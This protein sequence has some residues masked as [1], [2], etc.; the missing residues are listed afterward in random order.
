MQRNNRDYIL[1]RDM[2][3]NTPKVPFKK[4]F[5]I[6]SGRTQDA[7]KSM[8]ENLKRIGQ[9][10]VFTLDK[11]D[12]ILLFCPIAS[13]VGTDISEA[14]ENVPDDKQVIMVVMHH[15]FNPEHIVADSRRL[16]T[17]TNV[18]LVVDTLFYDGRFLD[19]NRN[20]IALHEIRTLLGVPALP[21]PVGGNSSLPFKKFFV[22][23]SGRTQDAHK[24]MVENLKRIDQVEVPTLE[25]S[26]YILLFCPIASREGMD[27]SEALENVPD[28][29]Q[30]IMVVMHHTFNPEHIVAD[31]RRLVTNTNVCLVVDTLF[32]DGHFLG[33]CNRNEIA[34]HEIRTLLGVPA[35]PSPVGGNSSLP[36]KKFF[37]IVSGRTQDAHKSMVENLKRI[38]QVEVSTLDKS[39]YILLFCP[40]ASREGMDVSE[41]LE[42]VPDDKQVIMV[43]MHH[44]FNPEQ[45]VA[46][47]RR[48]VTNPNVCLVVDTLFYDG[49][50][51]GNC[52]RNEIALYEMKTLLGVPALLSRFGGNSSL[53]FKKFF[54]I[55]SGRTQDAHKS[56]VENLK[57]IGQVEVP[58]LDKSDYILLFCPIPSREGMDVSEALEN[59]PDDKQVIMVVMH[60]TFNPK[61]TVADSR[62][63]VTNPNVC[64]VVDTLFYEGNL[65]G[66][67]NHNEIA[68]HEMKMLLGVPA[69]PSTFWDICNWFKRQKTSVIV[70]GIVVLVVTGIVIALVLQKNKKK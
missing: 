56:M 22:I 69:L 59:V 13:R 49:H 42:N 33:N 34:L 21:S 30:V 26:D 25:K 3:S 51:L 43:V 36:F 45:T 70:V 53:P 27:V 41:A 54:V 64:L 17:N 40:I 61:Q 39:D 55:V 28:D 5:V 37:V 67:C 20:E 50:F 16:V 58:T 2:E 12:Y 44:T 14:L 46:D 38:D 48:L 52:N 65:L 4:F 63:L 24:S 8:V 66:N 47:S 31:S 19:C 32:Y 10:E 6:V 29:K 1:L 7:H 15:T 11:S 35:L 68:L 62:R 18:C 60:H 9:V 57:R 23:V